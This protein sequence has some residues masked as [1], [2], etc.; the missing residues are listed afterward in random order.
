L[1]TKTPKSILKITLSISKSI[2]DI[3]NTWDEI[4]PAAHHLQSR[5]LLAFE[6]SLIEDVDNNYVQI[7]SK[8]KLIGVVYL[9][10][11][12][13]QHKHLNFT[14]D[15]QLKSRFIKL[16]LPKRLPLLVCG[17]LF[18]INFQGFYFKNE[19]H[20]NLVFDS[21]ELFK[22]QKNYR[23]CG[24][25]I[26]DCAGVFVEQQSKTFGYHFFNG[27]V[28]MEIH[29]RPHWKTFDDYLKDLHKKYL[30]RAKKVIKAF[31]GIEQKI[32][33][34]NEIIDHKTTIEKLYWNVVNKQTIKLG[35]INANYFYELKNDLLDN[36]E[37]YALYKNGTMV[38]FYTFILYDGEMET[39]FIGLDYDANK[40]HSIY[41][42]ILF[43][44]I[45]KMIERHYDKL[46]LGR[47]AKEAKVNVGA[48]P[49]QIFNYISVKNRFAK[50]TL[51]Y[52]LNRFNSVEDNKQMERTPLK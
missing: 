4:L 19:S 37:F 3:K 51:N 20:N 39:H 44:G 2:V 41:F 32:L 21:I 10:Q 42:N 7:F 16:I 11:F 36:F 34:A 49:K 28:T 29:R 27:D 13:F 18:R 23:P 38:G 25:I 9:Q 45:Q 24:I 33:S 14:N 8:E 47:T 46:E 5:H 22:Q 31:D 40:T 35:T 12:A 30:Q 48:L 1:S 15:K 43:L 52:F 50:I 6:K 17:H 26:K